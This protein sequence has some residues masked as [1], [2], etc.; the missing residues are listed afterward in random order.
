MLSVINEM[1][2]NCLR[3]LAIAYKEVKGN[4]DFET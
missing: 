2:S 3:T 1:A 4:E